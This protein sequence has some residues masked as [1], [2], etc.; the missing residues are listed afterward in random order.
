MQVDLCYIAAAM[1]KTVLLL[2]GT[3]HTEDTSHMIATQLVQWCTDCCLAADYNIHPLRHSF[4]CCTLGRVYEAFAG[5]ALIKSITIYIKTT[6]V[7]CLVCDSLPCQNCII[8]KF[9]FF[10]W[11]ETESTWYCGHCLAYCTSPR[12]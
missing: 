5:S 4:C 10:S 3:D 2:H 9:K 6:E 11:G 1:Q 12:R 8:L 7:L